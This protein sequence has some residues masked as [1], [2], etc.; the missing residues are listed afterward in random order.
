MYN[1]LSVQVKS[2]LIVF[3]WYVLLKFP[4]ILNNKKAVKEFFFQ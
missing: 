1:L 4:K 2:L 3:F